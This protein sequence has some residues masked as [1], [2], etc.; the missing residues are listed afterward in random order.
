[1][2]V[3]LSEVPRRLALPLVFAVLAATSCA[4]PSTSLTNMWRDPQFAP[5]MRSMMIMGVMRNP[6][7]RRNWEDRM[8][9][10]LATHHVH[11]VPSYSLF[12]GELPDTDAVIT[13]VQREGFDGVMIVHPLGTESQSHY[14]PGYVREVPTLGYDRWYGVY[15]NYYRHIYEPGYVETEQVV[16]HQIDVYSTGPDGRLVWTGTSES[17]DPASRDEVRLKV[18]DRVVAELVSSRVLNK[19]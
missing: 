1:M 12:P 7:A 5:P 16:R 9:E 2:S 14:V 4:G 3:A 6:A 19:G 8:S 17:V 10:E 15:Y 13:G 18:A 11:A